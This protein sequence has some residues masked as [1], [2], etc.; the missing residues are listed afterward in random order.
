LR[1]ATRC[2]ASW[3]RVRSSVS[4]TSK[5]FTVSDNWWLRWRS[6]STYLVEF[7]FT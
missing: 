5:S 4:S 6:S 7:I 1:I 2:S 3:T